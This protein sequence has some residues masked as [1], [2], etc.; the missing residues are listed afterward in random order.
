MLQVKD[1]APLFESVDQNRKPI[2][3]KDFLGKGQKVALYFYPKDSTT[4]CTVQACNLRDNLPAL[5]KAGYQIVGVSTDDVKSHTK[6]IAKN[7]LNFPLV[8]DTDKSVV[9]A[10]GVWQEKSMYGKKY[11]GVVRTTFIISSEGI[12]EQII[13]K[14]KTADHANQIMGA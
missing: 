7:E 2:S 13:D 12:I 11:M 6:F 8:A 1:K 3:L 10:Y 4:A 5:A 9:E 14:V